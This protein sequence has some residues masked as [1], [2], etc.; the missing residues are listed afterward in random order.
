MFMGF[1]EL[2][3]SADWFPSSWKFSAIISS[4]ISS[5]LYS[6]SGIPNTLSCYTDIV[7]ISEALFIFHSSFS[8]FFTLDHSFFCLPESTIESL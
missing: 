2:P 7:W 5:A 8:L 6:P 3:R 4:N 1:I